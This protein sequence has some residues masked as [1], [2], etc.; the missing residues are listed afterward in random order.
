MYCCSHLPCVFSHMVRPLLLSLLLLRCWFPSPG[1]RTEISMEKAVIGSLCVCVCACV[2]TCV[3]VWDCPD[4]WT[5]VAFKSLSWRIGCTLE[6]CQIFLGQCWEIVWPWWFPGR[7]LHLI[8]CLIWLQK[9]LSPP[10]HVSPGKQFW[11]YFFLF[12]FFFPSCRQMSLPLSLTQ[13]LFVVISIFT[14]PYNCEHLFSVFTDVWLYKSSLQPAYKQTEREGERDGDSWEAAHFFAAST[15]LSRPLRLFLS[16]IDLTVERRA[17]R[18]S[19]AKQRTACKSQRE[20][21]NDRAAERRERE[22]R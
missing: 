6:F 22:G 1:E 8:K 3:C 16:L 10:L 20:R 9:L 11:F 19:G 4:G 18:G 21:K 5:T 13:M 12:Y 2:R 17:K 15:S 14:S 7:I